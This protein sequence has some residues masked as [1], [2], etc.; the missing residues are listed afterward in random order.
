M[1]S[2]NVVLG[3]WYF[4]VVWQQQVHAKYCYHLQN[5]MLS[6]PQIHNLKECM[7]QE[8]VMNSQQAVLELRKTAK[9]L[10]LNE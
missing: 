9:K 3:A 6:N 5:Y 1:K 8:A 2:L 7:E 4:V 10:S